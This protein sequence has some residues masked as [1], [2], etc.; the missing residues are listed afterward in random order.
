MIDSLQP[1]AL[2]GGQLFFVG[3][4]W[5]RRTNTFKAVTSTS[6]EKTAIVKHSGSFRPY[7][8]ASVD[9]EKTCRRIY[10]DGEADISNIAPLRCS[11]LLR[12]VRR[13]EGRDALRARIGTSILPDP[14]AP[15]LEAETANHLLTAVYDVLEG[16]SHSCCVSEPQDS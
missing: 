14:G 15:L 10:P 3:N 12:C 9:E 5:R 1:G 11:E 13:H 7:D 8:E 6:D 16:A 2:V 4:A